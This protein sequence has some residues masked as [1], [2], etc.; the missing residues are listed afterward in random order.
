MHNGDKKPFVFHN[1]GRVLHTDFKRLTIHSNKRFLFDNHHY[2][3]TLRNKLLLP[4]RTLIPLCATP[5]QLD[6]TVYTIYRHWTFRFF[7]LLF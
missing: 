1:K 2:S 3:K 5:L 4:L 6:K 7:S